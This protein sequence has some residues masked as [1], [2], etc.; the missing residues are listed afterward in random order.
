VGAGGLGAPALLYFAAS[1]VGKICLF[2]MI[3][4]LNSILLLKLTFWKLYLGKLGIVDHDKVEL[5]NMHR[6]V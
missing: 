6:Q 3:V 2:L 1:G 5:S 4:V